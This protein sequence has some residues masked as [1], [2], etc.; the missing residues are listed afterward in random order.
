MPDVILRWLQ[1]MSTFDIEVEYR[2]GQNH[3]NADALS[4]PPVP[5]ETRGCICQQ[6][7]GN[8]LRGQSTP[9]FDGE[10]DFESCPGVPTPRSRL[11]GLVTRS[12]RLIGKECEPELDDGDETTV[13]PGT[14]PWGLLQSQPHETGPPDEKKDKT[15]PP[16]E[17]KDKTGS[18]GEEKDKTGPPGEKKDE[19][20]S[21]GEEIGGTRSPGGNPTWAGGSIPSD[22]DYSS[23]STD[24]E[25]SEE[26]EAREEDKVLFPGLD[27]SWT[28]EVI[29]REQD[30]N[31]AISRIRDCVERG[32]RPPN[33]DLEAESQEYRQLASRWTELEVLEGILVR[34]RLGKAQAVLP[35]NLR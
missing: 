18:P 21:P 25:Q 32:A 15:G 29:K 30:D 1:Y 4:R 22:E 27:Y 35:H 2:P 3:G 20:G 24:D 14:D 7:H 19:T 10:P 5:C 34:M 16:G 6:A 12:G 33:G 28:N 9:P 31:D 13:G 26:E 11:I 23:D 17:E 8:M